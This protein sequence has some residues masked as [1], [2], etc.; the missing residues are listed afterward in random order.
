MPNGDTI[1]K[2]ISILNRHCQSYISKNLKDFNIGSGQYIFILALYDNDGISQD[3]LSELL[4]ID[5]GTTAKALKRL[6]EYGYV[7]RETDKTDK[8]AY[9]V[10][11]TEKALYIKPYIFEI[12]EKASQLLS[13]NLTEEEKYLA[14]DL[15]KKMSQNS[16]LHLK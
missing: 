7:K 3:K 1:G 4:C 5:K 14:V 13:L 6:E 16:V 11:A 15:L 2:Y 8:R 12:L 10:Y 9:K